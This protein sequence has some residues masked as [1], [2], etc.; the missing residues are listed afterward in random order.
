MHI[1]PHTVHALLEKVRSQLRCPQCTKKVEVQI[2]SL[3]VIGD[4]FAVFQLHCKTCEA[5]ILLYATLRIVAVGSSKQTTTAPVEQILASPSLEGVKED[6]ERV[7]KNYS[8][9]LELEEKELLAL[10]HALK[11]TE[12]NFTEIFE[13]T[14]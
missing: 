10:R 5:H 12:G 2:Q 14:L 3:K 8:T 9:T 13:E 1:D 4:S 7:H 11:E 6:G